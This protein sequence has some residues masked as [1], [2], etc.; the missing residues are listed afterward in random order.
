MRKTRQCRN[1]G[2]VLALENFRKNPNYKGGIETQCIE[3]QRIKSLARYYKKK[4]KNRKKEQTEIEDFWNINE[5]AI[6]C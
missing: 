1:C 2:T 3:C 4:A 5:T 6:Y